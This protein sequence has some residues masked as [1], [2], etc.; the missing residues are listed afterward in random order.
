MGAELGYRNDDDDVVH[1]IKQMTTMTSR[2]SLA[3]VHLPAYT[4]FCIG[5]YRNLSAWEV[6]KELPSEN[7]WLTQD[8]WIYQDWRVL[9]PYEWGG[10]RITDIK[11]GNDG[12]W[13]YTFNKEERPYP[14]LCRPV[15]WAEL[16]LLHTFR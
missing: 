12:T 8:G 4:T 2:S 3:Y 14:L 10:P 6:R 11:P 15:N 5:R 9:L 16:E 7:V 13:R 1:M